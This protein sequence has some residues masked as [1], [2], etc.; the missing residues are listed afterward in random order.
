[1]KLKYL[2]TAAAEGIPAI[3][4]NC[5]VCVHAWER[6]GRNVRTRSGA[7]IDGRIKLDFPPDTYA[8][9]LRYRI[10]LYKIQSLL[11]TH[12]HADHFACDELLYRHGWFANLPGDTPP[13]TVYGNAVVG[14]KLNG[15]YRSLK[16][17]E[18]RV[19]FRRLTALETL[20]VEGYAV[21][22]LPARHMIGEGED[23]FIYHVE[24][25]GRRLLYAHDTGDFPE[26]TWRWLEGRNIH[27]A[28]L[29]CT[30]G[31]RDY[32]DGHM[33]LPANLQVRDRMLSIGAADAQT[34][35]A[36]NHFSHNGGA[37]HEALEALAG[38]EGIR[39]AYDGMELTV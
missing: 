2:G 1:M 38:P 17:L 18:G 7:L 37:S 23:C 29:D 39:V 16:D 32:S 6:G 8:H 20:D 30:Y 31:G 25:E 5:P 36:A 28:S 12:S 33:G 21:T 4:C 26:E 27:L 13:L 3:F 19:E 11:V 10:P 14:Q 15:L 9:M 22:P 34:V 35:F 24:R